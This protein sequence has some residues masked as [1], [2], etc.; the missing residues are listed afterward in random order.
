MFNSC[1]SNFFFKERLYM[2]SNSVIPSRIFVFSQAVLLSYGSPTG[3]F[4]YLSV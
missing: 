3:V 4:N 2:L 1:L